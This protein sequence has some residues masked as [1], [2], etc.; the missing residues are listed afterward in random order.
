MTTPN[1]ARKYFSGHACHTACFGH[2]CLPG[3]AIWESSNLTLQGM[4]GGILPPPPLPLTLSN[5]PRPQKRGNNSNNSSTCPFG[6]PA[7]RL[8]RASPGLGFMEH[9]TLTSSAT[10]AAAPITG[11]T[12]GS[13]SELSTFVTHTV[14]ESGV[15]AMV[16]HV[17]RRRAGRRSQ[18]RRATSRC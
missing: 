9:V 4:W 8:V 18:R 17:G 13:V 12:I 2:A 14:A 15:T 11:A 3:L 6:K 10:S 16:A 7:P 5:P 1:A